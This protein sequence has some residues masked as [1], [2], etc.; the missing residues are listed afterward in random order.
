MRRIKLVKSLRVNQTLLTV[1][2][3]ILE[4]VCNT[5]PVSKVRSVNIF[6]ITSNLVCNQQTNNA[7]NI[8]VTTLT[9]PYE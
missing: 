3:V 2:A 8:S 1:F 5:V 4:L 7:I 9:Q 6:T